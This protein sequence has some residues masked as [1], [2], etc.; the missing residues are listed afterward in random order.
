MP[1]DGNVS[2]EIQSICV[3]S[4]DS[5]QEQESDSKSP[6][7]SD[8]EDGNDIMESG[9]PAMQM[10]YQDDQIKNKLN[11]PTIDGTPVDEYRTPGYIAS[12]FP[13]LFPYGSADLRDDSKID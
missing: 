7:E 11:W 2:S 1:D 12:A 8:V 10:P 4:E 13:S 3:A 9:V 5:D 6:T